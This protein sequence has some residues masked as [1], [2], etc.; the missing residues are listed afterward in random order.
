MPRRE[1]VKQNE[2]PMISPWHHTKLA[3]KRIHREDSR[4]K[5]LKP[6]KYGKMFLGSTRT[7]DI[8][9]ERTMVIHTSKMCHFLSLPKDQRQS[10]HQ[11]SEVSYEER[12]VWK[13]YLSKLVVETWPARPS[14][15]AAA[16]PFFGV[17]F[18]RGSQK[19]VGVFFPR[20]IFFAVVG[21]RILV[22]LSA[23]H[24]SGSIVS[25]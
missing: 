13:Y 25:Q 19:M 9:S 23:C 21:S 17:S 22:F 11:P 18:F 16:L 20:E 5:T 4:K 6:N 15:E 24:F 1:D 7:N 14:L 2:V 3:S 8:P 10:I 12:S